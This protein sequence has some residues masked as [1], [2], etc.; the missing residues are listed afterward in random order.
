[1]KANTQTTTKPAA[2]VSVAHP[3]DP[4]ATL[5]KVVQHA[6]C[7]AV[8]DVLTRT[9]PLDPQVASE[10]AM[11]WR[12]AASFASPSCAAYGQTET[13]R[14]SIDAVLSFCAAELFRVGVP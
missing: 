6:T 12:R 11:L 1:M 4:R 14:V 9:K 5:D 8:L 3:H 10:H 13:P 2:K 7:A